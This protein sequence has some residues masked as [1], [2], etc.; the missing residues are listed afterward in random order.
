MSD[1]WE[2]KPLEK[3]SLEAELEHCRLSDESIPGMNLLRIRKALRSRHKQLKLQYSSATAEPI[4]SYWNA[5]Q[6]AHHTC[7]GANDEKLKKAVKDF[8]NENKSSSKTSEILTQATQEIDDLS[9][10]LTERETEL[11]AV[12]E[13][14]EKAVGNKSYSPGTVL[15]QDSR[16]RITL[17]NAAS[18]IPKIMERGWK[19][20]EDFTKQIEEIDYYLAETLPQLKEVESVIKQYYKKS[21]P[22]E[23]TLASL[24]E[25]ERELTTKLSR[26]ERGNDSARSVAHF[27]LKAGIIVALLSG[28]CGECGYEV[29]SGCN[30]NNTKTYEFSKPS[31]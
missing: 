26:R 8:E 15:Y 29:R 13:E 19:E 18:E 1:P 2:K 10:R 11:A 17:E 6:K 7:L 3:L 27:F 28:F 12:R 23:D 31:R 20:S 9:Q 30:I 25:Q 22:Q 16:F 5:I 21:K 14:L 4:I 24:T